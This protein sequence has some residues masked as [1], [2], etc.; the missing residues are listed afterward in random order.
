VCVCVFVC[1]YVCVACVCVCVFVCVY[2]CV[3]VCVFD[4]NNVPSV[5][6]MCRLVQLQVFSYV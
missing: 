2:V 3:F 5:D 6:V 1:V 4:G